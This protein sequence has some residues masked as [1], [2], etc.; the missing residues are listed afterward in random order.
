[1]IAP[2]L[3]GSIYELASLI[4]LIHWGIPLSNDLRPRLSYPLL[5]M[6]CGFTLQFS[7]FTLMSLTAEFFGAFLQ[8]RVHQMLAI[9]TNHLFWYFDYIFM[10]V[11]GSL[12]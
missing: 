2:P 1:M 12:I 9:F 3:S 7:T 5:S 4:E 11:I 10:V 6:C 8:S